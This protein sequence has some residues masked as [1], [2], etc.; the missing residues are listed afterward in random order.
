MMAAPVNPAAWTLGRL[1]DGLAQ[2]PAHADLPVHGLCSDSRSCAPGDL[3]LAWQGTRVH[4][5]AHLAA[6]ERTGA[7]ATLYDPEGAGPLPEARLPL[8]PV[9]GLR[10]LAGRLADRLFGEPSRALAVIGV[11]GTNGKTSVCHFLAQVF[12][13]PDARCGV[14]GT[15]GNGF[16]GELEPATHTTPDALALHAELARLRDA[17]ATRVAIEVSSHALDQERVSGVRFDTAVFTNLTHEHL[18]YHGDMDGY[19]A[20]KRRLFSQPGLRRAVLN[21]DDPQGAAWRAALDPQ[22]EVLG[23]GF[24]PAADLRGSGLRLDAD[25]LV[26]DVVHGDARGTLRSPLLGRFSASNLLAALGV[27]RLTGLDLDAA[28]QKLERVRTVPGRMERFGRAGGPLAVVDYAHTPDAL[29]A[30]LAALRDHCTGRLWCVF[31]CGGDRD[32]A[33]RPR[34]GAVAEAGADR[35]IVTDDNPRH[36]DGDA[37][38][39]AIV[40]GMRAPDRVEVVRDRAAAITRALAGAEEGDVVLVAGKGHETVQQVGDEVRPFSDRA[41]VRRLQEGAA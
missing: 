27:L 24:D 12:D 39:M 41:L 35:V 37:I 16:P 1:L 15:L 6:A 4:G 17:G 9:P 32:R 22:I 14:L 29:E 26:L 18:D 2:L 38:T 5:L 21:V 33:K 36:E 3:F 30:A 40:A 20:A 11:T 34:M 19:A 23:Y 25:G 13:A 28:L 10:G 7:V 31:G 8:L